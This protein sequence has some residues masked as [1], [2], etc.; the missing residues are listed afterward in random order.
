MDLNLGKI[1]A[2]LIN[3]EGLIYILVIIFLAA[4]F[5]AGLLADVG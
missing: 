1:K 4:F 5:L 3:K 2:K